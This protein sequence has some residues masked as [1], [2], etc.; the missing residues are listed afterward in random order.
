M[1]MTRLA[2]R[3]ALLSCS[4]LFICTSAR[5]H[6]PAVRA[7]SLS[8]DGR[9]AVV[10]ILH[11]VADGSKHFVDRV[12]IFDENGRAGEARFQ[13]QPDSPVFTCPI[14]L[15]RP[16]SSGGVFALAHCNIFGEGKG[17]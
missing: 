5:A 4:L 2:F 1:G 7:L 9:A 6:P 11:S 17:P 16:I 8:P 14:P 10:T 3:V 13:Y 12:T 15:T